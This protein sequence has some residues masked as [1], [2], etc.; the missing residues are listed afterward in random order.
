MM[1]ILP[2]ILK[3]E[4][5]QVVGCQDESPE[6]EQFHVDQGAATILQWKS[7][8]LTRKSFS[9]QTKSFTKTRELQEFGIV[10]QVF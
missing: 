7:F 5:K 9:C 10:L 6:K 2:E 1:M 8:A 3:S 4:L